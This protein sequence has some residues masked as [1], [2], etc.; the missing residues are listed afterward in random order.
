MKVPKPGLILHSVVKSGVL[1]QL[2]AEETE[3]TL[4]LVED[5]QATKRHGT[6]R[7]QTSTSC[8]SEA[9]CFKLPH[10]RL[11]PD[12]APLSCNGLPTAVTVSKLINLSFSQPNSPRTPDARLCRQRRTGLATPLPISCKQSGLSGSQSVLSTPCVLSALHE[13]Q[14]AHDTAD[15]PD[16]LALVEDDATGLSQ[17]ER[18]MLRNTDMDLTDTTLIDYLLDVAADSPPSR[19]HPPESSPETDLQLPPQRG[20]RL[21]AP[22]MDSGADA[23]A[24]SNVEQTARAANDPGLNV[25]RR[26]SRRG[27]R[28]TSE[29]AAAVRRQRQRRAAE[30]RHTRDQSAIETADSSPPLRVRRVAT[31]DNCFS[32]SRKFLL[33]KWRSFRQ[34][35]VEKMAHLRRYVTRQDFDDAFEELYRTSPVPQLI[36]PLLSAFRSPVPQLVH[37]HGEGVGAIFDRMKRNTSMSSDLNTSCTTADTTLTRTSDNQQGDGPPKD[38][39]NLT[40]EK[41]SEEG[42]VTT[43]RQLF[44]FPQSPAARASANFARHAALVDTDSPDVPESLVPRVTRSSTANLARSTLTSRLD[45]HDT[46]GSA[47]IIQE[48]RPDDERNF[49]RRRTT[50]EDAPADFLMSSSNVAGSCGETGTT[51]CSACGVERVRDTAVPGTSRCSCQS[52]LQPTDS[53]WSSVINQRQS[54][55]RPVVVVSNHRSVR[56]GLESRVRPHGSE[57]VRRS[58]SAV[59]EASEKPPELGSFSPPYQF[60]QTPNASVSSPEERSADQETLQLVSKLVQR[61]QSSNENNSDSDSFDEDGAEGNPHRQKRNTAAGVA[62]SVQQHPSRSGEATVNGGVFANSESASSKSERQNRNGHNNKVKNGDK[63]LQD[64]QEKETSD[65]DNG[66]LTVNPCGPNKLPSKRKLQRVVTAD[67][68]RKK[69]TVHDHDT[70]S[71]EAELAI[72]SDKDDSDFQKSVPRSRT[73]QASARASEEDSRKLTTKAIVHREDIKQKAKSNAVAPRKKKNIIYDDDESDQD[74][75]MA[76][77]TRGKR[78]Q[79]NTRGKVTSDTEDIGELVEVDAISQK[80]AGPV[81]PEQD[82]FSL[83]LSC[84]ADNTEVESDAILFA[85]KRT[86]SSAAAIKAPENSRESRS[87]S[88]TAPQPGKRKQ[89]EE[90]SL[91]E[92][93]N[94]TGSK[95]PLQLRSW[96]LQPVARFNGVRVEGKLP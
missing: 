91:P 40:P 4:Q 14:R 2:S 95:K 15:L 53:V 34:R 52:S 96:S 24:C 86:R 50:E 13:F 64:S 33:Q 72:D 3:S 57:S 51:W 85:S 47:S 80:S 77:P 44:S 23:E 19:P 88:S 17:V 79:P 36:K 20:T 84:E 67:S 12:R 78:Q 29:E 63:N 9:A 41:D 37:G 75:V 69:K 21:E 81:A 27:K 10:R 28:M 89:M 42:M 6:Y 65:A 38:K 90:V 87:S 7:P 32:A 16:I 48:A 1:P 26:K 45:E 62:V 73:R 54:A 39:E 59:F 93:N 70:N 11:P 49:G 8:V 94:K 82:V 5:G 76:K 92:K 56:P 46:A 61:L 68:K 43:E 30:P 60:G 55:I 71:S 25:R 31:G 83:N 35:L 66:P 22:S 18:Q 74:I 58:S